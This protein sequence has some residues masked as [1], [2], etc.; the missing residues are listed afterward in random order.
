MK[1]ITCTHPLIL[2]IPIVVL[3]LPLPGRAE[4]TTAAVADTITVAYWRFE[5]SLGSTVFDTSGYGNDGT[6]VGTT[7]VPG[8]FGNARYFNG[9]SDHV[10]VPYPTN[11][12]LNFAPDQSFTIEA[13]FKTTSTEQM[14]IVRK[15]LAPVP[16]YEILMA[17]GKV[18]A[19]IG[20]REDGTPPD[21]LLV[22]KS[23]QSYNDDQWHHVAL[24]RDRRLQKLFLYVDDLAAAQPVEDHF[25]YA[26]AYDIPLGIGVWYG[27]SMPLYFQ[28]TIDETKILRTASH[29]ASAFSPSLDVKPESIDFGLT[30]VAD[31]AIRQIFVSNIGIHDTVVV[32]GITSTNPAFSTDAALFDVPPGATNVLPLLYSPTSVHVDTGTIVLTSNDPNKPSAG[33]SIRGQGFLAGR[34]PLITRIMDIPNDQGR[35]VRVIWARSVYDGIVDSLT[36]TDYNIWRRIDDFSG[37]T[38]VSEYSDGEMFRKD[39]RLLLFSNDQLWDFIVTIPAVQFSQYAYVA[40]TLFDSTRSGGMHWSVFEVSAHLSNGQYLFS[41]ADSGYSTDNLSPYPPGHVAVSLA[42]D[43]VSLSW[44]QPADADVSYIAVYRGTVQSYIPTAMARI[45]TAHVNGYIDQNLA[46]ASTL[47]YRIAAVDK[48]GNQGN[49]S[50]EVGVS[51]TGVGTGDNLPT[52]FRLYQNYPNP[53]NPSSTIKYDVPAEA[54]V[55][56]KIYDVLGREVATL[57]NER[58]EAGTFEVSWNA[59]NNP[60][61]MYLVRMNAGTFHAASKVL[62]LK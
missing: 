14:R 57:L 4:P 26:L 54:Y 47:Y 31:T 23:N 8:R 43:G 6:A 53:F 59:G 27:S 56:L 21:T 41:P 38:R 30:M 55:V 28:G 39:G 17:G 48:A 19:I 2:L 3:L 62:V 45:G 44:D 49:F 22:I 1:P 29:P 13:W 9:T 25:P 20:N 35:Q 15:G 60:S 7:I 50:A 24:V 40:P 34:E 46:G 37:S 51:I 36:T 10:Y 5:E 33:V 61:G 32:T 11:G 18:G 58:K 52:R 42:A 16:G 12:S